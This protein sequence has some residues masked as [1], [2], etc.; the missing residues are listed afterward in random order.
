MK[1]TDVIGMVTEDAKKGEVV[2][3][4]IAGMG[5]VSNEALVNGLDK[6]QTRKTHELMLWCFTLGYLTCAAVTMLLTVL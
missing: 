2:S 1:N 6:L 3:V 4:S 5:N